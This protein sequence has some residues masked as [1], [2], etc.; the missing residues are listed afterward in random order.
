MSNP[1]FTIEI[2]NEV[3]A[4]ASAAVAPITTAMLSPDQVSIFDAVMKF[5]KDGRPYCTLGGLAG[6]GKTTLVGVIANELDASK[7]AFA[8]F[9]GKAASVLRRKL[10]AAGVEQPQCTTLHK[11][12]YRPLIGS[13][14]AISGWELNTDCLSGKTLVVVDEA[15]MLSTELWDDLC[16]FKVPILAV[17]DHGQLPPIGDNPGLMTK[18]HLRLEQIHRQ[19]VG[20]PIIAL[21]HHVRQGGN[22]RDMRH[23]A[24]DD[25]RLR[26]AKHA[27]EAVGMLGGMEALRA[28]ILD[29][30][31]ICGRNQT[32]MRINEAVRAQLGYG[33]P[34][35]DPGE[36]LIALRNFPP[37]YN[38]VRGVFR[39]AT[40][41]NPYETNPYG[42]FKGS[43]EMVDDNLLFNGDINA[44]Q[45][46]REKTFG[47]AREIPGEPSNFR[48]A[49]TLWD[50]GYAMTCHKAQGSQF[51]Q[52]VVLSADTFGDSDTRKRW[53]YTAVTRAADSLIL[54]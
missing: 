29:I 41:T 19:A 16:S 30:G 40:G 28:N 46:G 50:Y 26:Y 5:V 1:H 15:S 45:F 44:H 11:L 6:T 9:T 31:V 3:D 54:I 20:N 24:R 12:M 2:L 18:P 14:G 42:A 27:I 25:K 39:A 17:G 36:V 48:Q 33:G 23:L 49:G 13:G 22:P 43:I 32:R 51:N 47:L 21:A 4:T 37:V 34:L 52:C 7:I 35:P 38:G 8:A 10:I 53:L